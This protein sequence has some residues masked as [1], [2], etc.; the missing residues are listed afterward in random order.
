MRKTAVLAIALCAAVAGL[1]GLLHAAPATQL[2]GPCA[3]VDG[4]IRTADDLPMAGATVR[5][6]S[7][8]SGNVMDTVLAD[9]SGRFE[10]SN[11]Q[12]GTYVVE[13]LDSTGNIVGTSPTI[14]VDESCKPVGGLIIRA[15]ALPGP[16]AGSF[17]TSTRGILLLAAAGTAGVILVRELTSPSR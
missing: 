8:T 16:V 14:E 2:P 10:F 1:D 6:R 12:P 17:F 4:V 13:I 15:S 9:S 3:T 7:V 5:L 11:V